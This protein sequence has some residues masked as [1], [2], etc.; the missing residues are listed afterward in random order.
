VRGR[1]P[2]FLRSIR[3]RL[4]AWY[5]IL[6]LLLIVTL[7]LGLAY[8]LE[9]ELRQDVDDRLLETATSMNQ[10][11]QVSF[12]FS[13][14]VVRVPPPDSFS[15][16]SQ[17]IEVVGANRVWFSSENLGDRRLLDP[18]LDVPPDRPRYTTTEVDGVPVRVLSYP[19]R[20]SGQ[21][22]GLVSVGEPLIQL[23]ET[24]DQV[25]RLLGLLAVTGVGLAAVGGWFLATRAL[26]PVDRM[27][28]TAGGLAFAAP[29]RLSLS[30][31]LDV[32][33]TGDEL[34]RLALTFNALLDRLE[35][36]FETQQRFI[37]DAS[38]E[39]RTPLTAIRGN[40]DLLSKQL[41]LA[42]ATDQDVEE[43][44]QALK[45]ESERM[46]RL[47]DDLL[48]LARAEAQSGLVL[49]KSTVELEPLLREAIETVQRAR[50]T[51]HIRVVI[52]PT[53]AV[54]ADRDRL[55]QV[56][57]NLL[58]NAVRYT[59][60]DGVIDVMAAIKGDRLRL[61]V[62]DT[63]SGINA[64]ELPHVFD[65]FFRAESARQRSTGGTGLGLAIVQAIV[66]AHQGTIQLES[67]VDRGTMVTITLPDAT[68]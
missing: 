7:F 14:P 37:A 41:A 10:E 19:I 16:P 42:T 23:D 45:R 63:G 11:F 57:V 59:P 47:T 22:I 43:T 54:V 35:S 28:A 48:T 32:P 33:A 51:P 34:S 9:R 62:N 30:T 65:R 56:L 46:A 15:F 58:D 31:R 60:T 53:L 26:A 39:L 49:Q 8:L 25:R 3:F 2:F 64:A 44:I 29:Q 1:V 5:A 27:T 67:E 20:L 50:P 36:A 24:L 21:T 12:T 40:V 38:H 17:L 4:T 13:G 52:E 66:R 68:L 18:D 55:A 61:T 6:L